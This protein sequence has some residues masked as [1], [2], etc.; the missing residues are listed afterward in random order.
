LEILRGRWGV[1]QAKIYE[2]KYAA[3]LEFL[4]GWGR[5]SSQNTIRWGGLEIW[6]NTMHSNVQLEGRVTLGIC[7]SI[8]SCP[9]SLLKGMVTVG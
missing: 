9:V 2:G 5:G 7:M 6:N 8:Y 3:N 4:E 1:S